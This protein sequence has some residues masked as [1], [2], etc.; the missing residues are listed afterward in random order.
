M[1]ELDKYLGLDDFYKVCRASGKRE[2]P[3]ILR[4]RDHNRHESLRFDHRYEPYFIRMNLLQFVLNFKGTPPWMNS[5][6]ITALTDR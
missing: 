6:V 4:L 2:V 5:T 1:F 3:P